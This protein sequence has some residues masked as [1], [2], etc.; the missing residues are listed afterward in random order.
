LLEGGVFHKEEEIYD[1]EFS[2]IPLWRVTASREATKLF[3]L[4]KEET[5]TYYLSA[6]TAGLASLEKKQIVFHKLLTSTTEKLRNLDE[7]ERMTFVPKLP[8]EIA[9][10]PEIRFGI[11]TAYQTL[12]LKIG[13]KPVSAEMILLPAWSLKVQHKRKKMKRTI[14]L[15]AATGRLLVGH[16]QKN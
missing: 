1:A 16:F 5:R 4:K 12:E 14:N 2:Y 6:Q 7:D 13:I 3:L 9:K 10:F 11:D 8:S 15:D